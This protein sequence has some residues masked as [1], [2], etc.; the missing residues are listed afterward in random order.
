MIALAIGSIEKFS[1][2][3]K[4]IIN[5]TEENI[6]SFRK[7]FRFQTRWSVVEG[8]SSPFSIK[9]RFLFGSNCKLVPTERLGKVRYLIWADVGIGWGFSPMKSTVTSSFSSVEAWVS[10][11]NSW[12]RQNVEKC[13][14][15]VILCT[16][17]MWYLRF[18]LGWITIWLS[19]LSG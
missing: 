15:L 10:L 13:R 17:R 12:L 5:F 6:K 3:E 9:W 18:C 2:T 1:F 8:Y 11:A 14:P 16:G 7:R 4:R 19:S